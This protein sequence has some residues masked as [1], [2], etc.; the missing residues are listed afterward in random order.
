MR[1]V[2]HAADA[3]TLLPSQRDH[4]VDGLPIVARLACASAFRVTRRQ[5]GPSDDEY[6]TAAHRLQ[7]AVA[8]QIQQ[9]QLRRLRCDHLARLR[10]QSGK[11]REPEPQHALLGR[12]A[13][14]G[15][16]GNQGLASAGGR[17][18]HQRSILLARVCQPRRRA[19]GQLRIQGTHIVEASHDAG[20]DLFLEL[21]E[22]GGHVSVQ[23][24]RAGVAGW[25]ASRE[26][27]RRCGNARES[28]CR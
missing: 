3:H 2:H 15:L 7:V 1:L 8:V 13:P 26:A 27:N 24:V 11:R 10:H 23:S 25:G 28:N 19:G 21:L 4:V 9:C 5:R 18:Q 22:G 14:H 12:R 17:L 16:D 20:T 6:A